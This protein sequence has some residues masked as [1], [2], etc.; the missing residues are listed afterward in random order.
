LLYLKYNIYIKLWSSPSAWYLDS[1]SR[2]STKETAIRID[3]VT[4]YNLYSSTIMLR[5]CETETLHL[6]ECL[7]ENYTDELSIQFIPCNMYLIVYV[8]PLFCYQDR[9][10]MTIYIYG[11]VITLHYMLSKHISNLNRHPCVHVTSVQQRHGSQQCPE[12]CKRIHIRCAMNTNYNVY[13]KIIQMNWVYSSFHTICISLCML[14][15]Y[16]VTRIGWT[17]RYTYMEM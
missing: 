12:M 16:S 14:L 5:L 15:H 13:K 8:S 17:W 4:T 2:N 7:Q 9:M 10:N 6:T 1:V 11:D 3:I